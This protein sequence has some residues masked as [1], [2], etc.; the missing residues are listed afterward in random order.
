MDTAGLQPAQPAPPSFGALLRQYRLAAGLSQEA[1]AERAGLSVQALSAL[2]NG[3][4]QV[5]YR[6]TVAVLARALALSSPETAALDTASCACACLRR[7][8][9]RRHLPCPRPE[10]LRRRPRG[11]TCPSP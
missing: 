1:L 3:R 6:H 9:P 4:R 11:T 8:R 7:L 5:P 10:G 2:E